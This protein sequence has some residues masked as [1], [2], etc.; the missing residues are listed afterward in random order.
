MAPI[1]HERINLI[2]KLNSFHFFTRVSV[3]ANFQLAAHLLNFLDYVSIE[4]RSGVKF[5]IAFRHEALRSE[6]DALCERKQAQ[7]TSLIQ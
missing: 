2:S 6:V 3:F 5:R 7:S 1:A 4:I